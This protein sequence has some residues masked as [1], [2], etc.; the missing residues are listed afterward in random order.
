MTQESQRCRIV[1]AATAVALALVG[2]G[3][4]DSARAPSPDDEYDLITKSSA[5]G[6]RKRSDA[7]RRRDGRATP[8]KKRSELP[9]V[10]PKPSEDESA[11]NGWSFAGAG[12][13]AA[14][15]ATMPR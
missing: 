2:C 10:E 7:D 8:A 3:Q 14:G 11:I 1:L 12:P 5:R 9:Q 4:G 13:V 15:E 6:A